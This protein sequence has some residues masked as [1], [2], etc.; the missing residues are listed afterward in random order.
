MYDEEEITRE[1]FIR[2]INLDSKQL[3]N[4]LGAD[5]A[6]DL[7]T[8]TVGDTLD[9]RVSSLPVEEADDEFV[10]VERK[11][12]SKRARSVFGKR[13]EEK[14]EKQSTAKPKGKRSIKVRGQK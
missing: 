6:A 14:R 13:A 7:M 2:M 4:V 1:Q 9:I 12:G 10:M 5:Q 8:V 11:I 3:A